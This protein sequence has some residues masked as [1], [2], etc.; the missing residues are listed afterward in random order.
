MGWRWWWGKQVKCI[1]T[2]T[3]EVDDCMIWVMSAVHGLEFLH[4][5]HKQCSFPPRRFISFINMLFM[6]SKVPWNGAIRTDK[7]LICRKTERNVQKKLGEMWDKALTHGSVLSACL[8]SFFWIYYRIQTVYGTVIGCVLG[9]DSSGSTVSNILSWKCI[10]FFSK[11][12][13]SWIWWLHV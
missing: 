12:E 1:M 7:K 6:K 4:V 11:A 3:P 9:S 8:G 5:N 10:A 13:Q 2:W